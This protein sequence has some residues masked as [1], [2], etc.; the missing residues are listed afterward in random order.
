MLT[1]SWCTAHL[2]TGNLAPIIALTPGLFSNDSAL[3]AALRA[4][5]AGCAETLHPLPIYDGHRYAC[6]FCQ[7]LLA[8]R[9]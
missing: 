4:T 8:T 7:T 9:V 3:E 2:H 1:M 5:G 6:V